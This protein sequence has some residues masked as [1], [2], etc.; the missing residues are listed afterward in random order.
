MGR[1]LKAK[2]PKEGIVK[3]DPDPRYLGSPPP[4]CFHCLS[5]TA[6]LPRI[7][8]PEC[9]ANKRGIRYGQGGKREGPRGPRPSLAPSFS[10]LPCSLSLL[11]LRGGRILAGYLTLSTLPLFLS[12]SSSPS[13]TEAFLLPATRMKVPLISPVGRS[14]T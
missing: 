6:C 8:W 4:I 10:Q 1:E 9:M 7:H 14:Q 3:A 12:F 2:E 11:F 13:S 5:A